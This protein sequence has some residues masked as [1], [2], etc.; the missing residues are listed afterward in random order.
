MS[1]KMNKI[2]IRQHLLDELI[3]FFDT[4]RDE[5]LEDRKEPEELFQ[6]GVAY[7]EDS[8]FLFLLLALRT[9]DDPA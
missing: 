8:V 6:L 7:G 2:A 5:S 9:W 4:H 3:A 1:R